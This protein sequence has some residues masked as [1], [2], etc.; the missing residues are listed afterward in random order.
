MLSTLGSGEAIYTASLIDIQ[1]GLA[2]SS[3]GLQT[4]ILTPTTFPLVSWVTDK[5]Q[6]QS[7]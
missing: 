5:S 7:S 4:I 2:V 3:L 1:N 6:Y